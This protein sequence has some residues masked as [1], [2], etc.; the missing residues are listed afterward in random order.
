MK[1]APVRP[2]KR[3]AD[4]FEVVPIKSEKFSLPYPSNMLDN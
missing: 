4:L 3:K 1:E 2:T